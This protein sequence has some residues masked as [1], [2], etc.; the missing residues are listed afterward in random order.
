MLQTKSEVRKN[1]LQLRDSLTN[2]ERLNM[3]LDISKNVQS[4][5]SYQ[6]ADVI[7]GY[8]SYKSEV[9]TDELLDHAQKDG[10]AIFV[11]KVS[12]DSMT[13]WR[14]ENKEQLMVGY[15]GILEPIETISFEEWL[16]DEGQKLQKKTMQVM[17]WIPGSVF[18]KEFHRIGYGKGFYDRF[19]DTL[20]TMIDEDN[21]GNKMNLQTVGLCYSLQMLHKIPYEAHD[22]KPDIIVTE[23]QIYHRNR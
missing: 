21:L 2:E 4:M 12:G 6:D 19:L 18:D 8:V 13:F 14:L 11:P 22:F 7:L 9:I 20:S 3:S 15:R 17:M 10:K 1:V 23:K 16:S 5:Q